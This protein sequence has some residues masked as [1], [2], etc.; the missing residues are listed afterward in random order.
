[1]Y[2]LNEEAILV[3]DKTETETV[4]FD[5]NLAQKFVGVISEINR[6]NGYIRVY[7]N[8]N[9]KYY[10]FK[11]EEKNSSD[12]LTKNTIYLSK[13][14]GKYGFVDKEGNVVVDY[15]YDDATEQNQYG[16]AAVKL[17]GVWGSVDKIGKRVLEPSL[18]LDDSIYTYFI[19]DWHLSNSG[20]Y[21][22]K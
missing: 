3:A 21:Y 8:D 2:Y 6:Q 13:K 14:N 10:N 18:N 1:M 12:V 20:L 15:I 22:T 16:Y 9:Y 19:A 4:V 17:N 5:S 11:F 7:T